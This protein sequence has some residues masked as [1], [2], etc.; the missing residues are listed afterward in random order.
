MDK[1]RVPFVIGTIKYPIDS[2]SHA[3]G[4][5]WCVNC[6]NMWIATLGI[7]LNIERAILGLEIVVL[8]E[9]THA[10]SGVGNCCPYVNGKVKYWDETIERI[11]K[12]VLDME[13]VEVW[14]NNA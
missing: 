3:R 8:H 6:V 2:D 12:E 14:E 11:M 4:G 7:R 10:L 1:S 9:I 13:D 5:R